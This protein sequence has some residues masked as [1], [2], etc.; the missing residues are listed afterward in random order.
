MVNVD[1]NSDNSD[2]VVD[3]NVDNL[4]KEE[5]KNVEEIENIMNNT[6]R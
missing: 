1:V 5:K 3:G 2:R 4:R 6:S